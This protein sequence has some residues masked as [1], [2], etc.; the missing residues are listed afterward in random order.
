[1]PMK[2]LTPGCGLPLLLTG[3]IA[4]SGCATNGVM[5]D[6]TDGKAVRLHYHHGFWSQNRA[7]VDDH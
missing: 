1:M 4:L 7:D 3:L 2:A 6:R 5:Q